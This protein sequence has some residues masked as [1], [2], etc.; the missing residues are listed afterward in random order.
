MRQR[1]AGLDGPEPRQPI[2]GDGPDRDGNAAPRGPRHG[3]AAR[4][5]DQDRLRLARPRPPE[6]RRLSDRGPPRPTRSNP[7]RGWPPAA[8]KRTKTRRGP[9][10]PASSSRQGTSPAA[11]TRS[12]PA[13]SGAFASSART[14]PGGPR[15]S[16][17]TSG[18]AVNGAPPAMSRPATSSSGSPGPTSTLPRAVPV[19]PAGVGHDEDDPVDARRREGMAHH[20]PVP[21]SA[22]AEAPPE[23]QGAAL[24]IGRPGRVE[25]R[26]LA[27]RHGGR[28]PERG[29]RRLVGGGGR[30][31]ARG[32]RRTD[33]REQ[34]CQ[35]AI[36]DGATPGS[37]SP[38]RDCR[39]P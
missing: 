34:A 36:P 27:G 24:G 2:G 28:Q 4:R 11:G 7:G 18:R 14:A 35:R 26:Q 1:G 23:R 33:G 19:A 39:R 5:A 9:S 12:A 21:H 30:D 17:D 16:T 10:G 38:D 29:H 32:D 22:V 37:A 13:K 6:R 20:L 31:G 3:A 8:R 15:T 25:A